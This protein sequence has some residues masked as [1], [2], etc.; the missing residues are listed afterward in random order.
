MS[1][2]YAKVVK[3]GQDLGPDLVSAWLNLHDTLTLNE[4]A[5]RLNV[6]FETSYDMNVL[7]RWR[8]AGAATPRN[9]QAFMRREILEYINLGGLAELLEAPR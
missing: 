2:T 5:A 3:R 1:L 6:V 4:C 7:C 9:V 8:R